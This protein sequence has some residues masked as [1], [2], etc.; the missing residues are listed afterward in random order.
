MIQSN[1]PGPTACASWRVRSLTHMLPSLPSAAK[2]YLA[3]DEITLE[4]SMQEKAVVV[5]L[6]TPTQSANNGAKYLK[7]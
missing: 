1:V 4:M 5:V 2:A 7:G 6:K 3:S